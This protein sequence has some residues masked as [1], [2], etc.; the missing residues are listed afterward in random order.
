MNRGMGYVAFAATLIGGLCCSSAAVAQCDWVHGPQ[1]QLPGLD[2]TSEVLAVA[3]YDDGNGPAL[4]V[5][6]TIYIAG[7]VRVNNIA[8]WDGAVW[9]DVGGGTNNVVRA[10]YVYNGAL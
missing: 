1:F 7:H 3:V 6:G 5:G 4:Y 2:W 9:S 10:L 8:K